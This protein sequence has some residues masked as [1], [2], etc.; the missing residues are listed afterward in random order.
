MQ[1]NDPLP[2]CECSILVIVLTRV[3]STIQLN[4]AKEMV[5]KLLGLGGI[6]GISKLVATI[7]GGIPK[8]RQMAM[9][10]IEYLRAIVRQVVD[11]THAM[12][13][14][15][16]GLFQPRAIV[17]AYAQ[18]ARAHMRGGRLRSQCRALLLPTSRPPLVCKDIGWFDCNNPETLASTFG[19]ALAFIEGGLGPSGMNLICYDL[20][21]ICSGLALAVYV[22]PIIAAVATSI[23]PV[24]FYAVWLSNHATVTSTRKISVAYSKAGGVASEALGAIRTIASLGIEDQMAHRY[25]DRLSEAMREGIKKLL[26]LNSATG[27]LLGACPMM[28]SMCLVVGA[29]L[30]RDG[31]VDSEWEY[32]CNRDPISEECTSS[33]PANFDDWESLPTSFCVGRDS[34]NAYDPSFYLGNMNF[35]NSSSPAPYHLP[36]VNGVPVGALTRERCLDHGMQNLK[37]TCFSTCMLKDDTRRSYFLTPSNS[38]TWFDAFLA[39]V[40]PGGAED[41]ITLES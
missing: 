19:E 9:Y 28:M 38:S 22:L 29:L 12:S 20:G 31:R 41:A 11:K 26:Q 17:S 16:L 39:N 5:Y 7:C 32:S 13:K 3:S 4:L 10:R 14:P 30:V 24:I 6:A 18:G 34:C 23:F 15:L 2:L 36:L 37:L 33:F 40:M 35:S 1:S 25:T 8:E 27:I 21:Q